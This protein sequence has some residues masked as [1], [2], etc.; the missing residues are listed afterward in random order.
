MVKKGTKKDKEHEYWQ[1]VGN[2]PGSIPDDVAVKTIDKTAQPEDELPLLQ[3]EVRIMEK[4]HHPNCVKLYQ[5]FESESHL[6]MVLDLCSGGELFERIIEKEKYSEKEAAHV[7]VQVAKAIQYMHENG[8][9]HRDLKPENLLYATEADD[10]IIKV[11]DFGLAKYTMGKGD[12]AEQMQT[13]CGTPGYVA[14]EIIKTGSQDQEA[15][16]KEVDIWSLGV[17]L[18]ILLCGYPPFYHE[19]NSQLFDL[20]RNAEFDFPDDPWAQISNEAKDLVRKLLVV[21]PKDRLPVKEVLEHPWVKETAKTH[22][23]NI[24]GVQDGL[25]KLQ[26][27]ARWRK[28]QARIRIVQIMGMGKGGGIVEAEAKEAS[29][30]EA[31]EAPAA[32]AGSEAAATAA[33]TE[34]DAAASASGGQSSGETADAQATESPAAE[35]AAAAQSEQPASEPST[36]GQA[37]GESS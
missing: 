5:F 1:T 19:N 11:T 3:E 21:E 26:A 33:T 31:K 23:E 37:A 35:T 6:H 13:A 22:E 8:V 2:P 15:Y 9:V 4:L 17:I 18:Y 12:Y 25:K 29:A 34:P 16:G 10:S 24:H 30:P 28:A 14:P 27:K 36:A 7:V 32:D 20:I